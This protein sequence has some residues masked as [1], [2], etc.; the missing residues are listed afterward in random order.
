MDQKNKQG[1]S[2]SFNCACSAQYVDYLDMWIKW[3]GI[4]C[5][6]WY[7]SNNKSRVWWP[8]GSGQ[9]YGSFDFSSHL[10]YDI[11]VERIEK[12]LVLL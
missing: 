9:H 10:P 6:Y 4:Y 8:I 12:L 11:T 1:G 5:I 3:I 2:G 7:C